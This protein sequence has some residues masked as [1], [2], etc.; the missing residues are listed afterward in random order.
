MIL[1]ALLGIVLP[2]RT[3]YLVADGIVIGLRRQGKWMDVRKFRGA[4]G[5]FRFHEVGFA[6]SKR[7]VRA[8]EMGWSEHGLANFIFDGDFPNGIFY[9]GQAKWPRGVTVLSNSNPV[10]LRVVADL[11]KRYHFKSKPRITKL[12]SA[13]L[14][15]DGTR[16]VLIEASN[17]DGVRYSDATGPQ[18]DDY[19]LLLLRYVRQGRAVDKEIGF[20]HTGDGPAVSNDLRAVA[21]FCGDGTLQIVSTTLFHSEGGSHLQSFR[22][23]R[24]RYLTGDV[25]SG[26]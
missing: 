17:R 21:D 8:K 25:N 16:E 1:A 14:D 20:Y 5:E 7:V 19:T 23:G 22:R 24:L 13:D 10:Y 2:P 4:K 15:G 26:S 6:A 11:L 12:V 3:D 9:T 18:R